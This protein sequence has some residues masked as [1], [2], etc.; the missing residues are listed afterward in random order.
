MHVFKNIARELSSSLEYIFQEYKI[1]FTLSCPVNSEAGGDCAGAGGLYLEKKCCH[2]FMSTK[3]KGGMEGFKM[4]EAL[5]SPR[6]CLPGALGR[7]PGP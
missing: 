6:I 2:V 5:R 1:I 7:S 4:Y 3:S